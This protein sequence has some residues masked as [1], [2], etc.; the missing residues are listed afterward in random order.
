MNSA[1][2]GK[3]N[4]SDQ[5]IMLDTGP[6]GT[7]ALSRRS[8]RPKSPSQIRSVQR[9]D[10]RPTHRRAFPNGVAAGAHPG[11]LG[12]ETE[13]IPA[14]ESKMILKILADA[15]WPTKAVS[16]RSLPMS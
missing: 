16:G 2:L 12:P 9:S 4:L 14:D 15:D 5:K 10:T 8:D 11:K 7:R 3:S 13:P 6:L 1:K